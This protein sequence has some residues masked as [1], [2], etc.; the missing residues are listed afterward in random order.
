MTKDAKVDAQPLVD[1]QDPDEENSDEDYDEGSDGDNDLQN[2][3]MRPVST[4]SKIV[5]NLRKPEKGKNYAPDEKIVY[6][7][8]SYDKVRMQLLKENQQLYKA[9]EET[10]RE[11][12]SKLSLQPRK[13]RM[14]WYRLLPFMMC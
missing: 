11:L 12:E 7:I 14:P 10:K 13:R 1:E 2:D 9:F 4:R 3:I 6:E 5:V 8:D